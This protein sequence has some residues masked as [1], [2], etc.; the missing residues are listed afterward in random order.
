MRENGGVQ[1][2]GVLHQTKLG[3]VWLNWA[4]LFSDSLFIIHVSRQSRLIKLLKQSFKQRGINMTIIV[5]YCTSYCAPDQWNSLPSDS[6]HSLL[7]NCVKNSNMQTVPQQMISN[8]IFLIV[9]SPPPPTY[10]PSLP[11]TFLLCACMHAFMHGG[12]MVCEEYY[13]MTTE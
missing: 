13:I 9:T 6:L 12:H 7:K 2:W 5:Q 11:I 3:A 10:P 4:L 8:Y 1:S